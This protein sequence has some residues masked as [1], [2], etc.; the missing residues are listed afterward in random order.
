MSDNNMFSPLFSSLDECSK[1]LF[2]SI[3]KALN[4]NTLDF[5]KLFEEL[6]LCNKS[7]VENIDIKPKLVTLTLSEEKSQSVNGEYVYKTAYAMSNNF[8]LSYHDR[9]ISIAL[10]VGITDKKAWLMMLCEYLSKIV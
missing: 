6:S 9:K 1:V 5:K 10:K 7:K 4:I 2:K 3:K 8:L